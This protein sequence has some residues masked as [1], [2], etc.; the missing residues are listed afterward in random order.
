MSPYSKIPFICVKTIHWEV[1][2]Y[3]IHLNK[4]N[5]DVSLHF[6]ANQRPLHFVL[7]F[8][9]KLNVLKLNHSC[10]ILIIL[11]SRFLDHTICVV[12]IAILVVR[13][14]YRYIYEASKNFLAIAVMAAAANFRNFLF[15]RCSLH[16]FGCFYRRS[17]SYNWMA[18][19]VKFVH[20]ICWNFR[21]N[22]TSELKCCQIAGPFY[23]D[24][25]HR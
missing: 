21:H 11:F 10:N 18:K 19:L 2:P 13:Y 23:F 14:Y 22:L 9:I 17:G 6:A 15:N 3:V 7:F 24:Y 8:A 1:S 16:F 5:P 25:Y 4:T 12:V 20:G